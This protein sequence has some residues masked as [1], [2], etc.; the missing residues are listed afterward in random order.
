MA[1]N[2]ETV[3]A[4]AG[5]DAPVAVTPHKCESIVGRDNK[6]DRRRQF[7]GPP[8]LSPDWYWETDEQ[9]RFLCVQVDRGGQKKV[10]SLGVIGKTRREIAVDAEEPSLLLC[11]AAFANRE[12]FH[13]VRY[14]AKGFTEGSVRHACVSGEPRYEDGVFKGYVGVGRYIAKEMLAADELA[15]LAEENRALVDNSLDIIALIDSSGRFLRINEAAFDILGYRPAELLGRQY[16][17]LL[18]P[19]E[20]ETVADR[21]SVV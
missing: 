6:Q 21:K 8:S 17:E 19:E 1:I 14:S 9:D 5:T 11:S 2:S 4:P 10:A 12:P 20:H 3:H 7:Q 18:H 13:N 15:L 16:G